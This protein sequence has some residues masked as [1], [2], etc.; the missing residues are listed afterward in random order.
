[1]AQQQININFHKQK[2]YALIVAGVAFIA[3]LLPWI[4]VQGNTWRTGFSSWGII[5]LLG[6]IAVVAVTLMG[7]K[8]KEYEGSFNNIS[9]KNIAMGGFIAVAFGALLMMLTKNNAVGGMYRGYGNIVKAG[10][11]VWLALLAGG[12]GA[13]WVAGKIKLPEN[14]KPPESPKK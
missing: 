3:L 12:A 2:L 13:L 9:Y 14:K 5:S 1:M 8:T 11:G 7:D 4:T 6:I 10:F